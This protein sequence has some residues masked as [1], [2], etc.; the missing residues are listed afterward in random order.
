M[1]GTIFW[2]ALALTAS[3]VQDKGPEA[4]PPKRV[5]T[6]RAP[7]EPAQLRESTLSLD[8]YGRELVIVRE[9]TPGKRVA[10]FVAEPRFLEAGM[11]MVF[12]ARSEAKSG[13]VVRWRCIATQDV[14]ECLGSPVRIAYLPQDERVVLVA[15]V[16]PA[17]LSS[18]QMMARR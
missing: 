7:L 9:R 14:A 3:G 8:R 10:T 1:S 15:R 4:P 13:S 18:D 5:M 6:A 2:V 16:E 11:R 17:A 12:E